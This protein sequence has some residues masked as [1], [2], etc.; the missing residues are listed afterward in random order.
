MSGMF[1]GFMW[2][3]QV[4][5]TVYD[6]GGI[7]TYDLWKHETASWLKIWGMCEQKRK[8]PSLSLG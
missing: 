7:P 2:L 8:E 3:I 4:E 5:E 6:V 1:P